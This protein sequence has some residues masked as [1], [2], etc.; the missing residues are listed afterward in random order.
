[1]FTYGIWTTS[2]QMNFQ[3]LNFSPTQTTHKIRLAL[4][5]NNRALKK[6]NLKNLLITSIDKDKPWGLFY[7]ACQGTQAI[8]GF[9]MFFFN[10]TSYYFLL[11]YATRQGTN[12]HA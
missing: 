10:D 8:C 6:K 12:N 2:N 1:M 7:G 11:R 9:G 4:E 3:D 5:G